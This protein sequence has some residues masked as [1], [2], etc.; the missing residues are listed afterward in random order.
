[1]KIILLIPLILSEKLVSVCTKFVLE[2]TG[3]NFGQGD[4][5]F[6]HPFSKVSCK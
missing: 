5:F 1:M 3:N 2:V 4:S 6:L